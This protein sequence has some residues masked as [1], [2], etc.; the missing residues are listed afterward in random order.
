MDQTGTSI[1]RFGEIEDLVKSYY[2]DADLDLIRAAYVY[3]GQVHLGQMRVGGEPYL[4]HP[5]AVAKIL[6]QMKLD[7]AAVATGLLH[8]TVEDT[9]STAEDI[10]RFF[11]KEIAALVDGVT[12]ISKMEFQS[13]EERQ[14]ENF[15]KMILAM[16]RDIRVLLV[17]LADRL[18][19]MRTLGPMPR[20]AQVRIARETQEI[21]APLA[22]RLGIFWMKNALEDLSFQYLDPERY[23]YI[24]TRLEETLKA[25]EQYANNVLR[26]VREK[27]K[28]TT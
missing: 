16:S 13:R 7:E 11:G 15:R 26:I 20:E 5:V 18:H 14:A 23:A 21:Y 28:H 4:V 24:K 25:R 3:S 10:E 17:K 2:P 27:L 9:L 22:G 12:K 6:A 19:N 8:D 1:V